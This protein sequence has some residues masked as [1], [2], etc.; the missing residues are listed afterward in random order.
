MQL[1]VLSPCSCSQFPPY[2]ATH[3]DLP[4]PELARYEAQ[5]VAITRILAVFE[6][7]DY[8]DEDEAKKAEIVKL[9]S[10]VRLSCYISQG[11]FVFSFPSGER[12][13]F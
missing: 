5:Q 7:P 9:M 8:S 3:T 11:R 10:E 2:L 4:A 1:T 6:A 12:S 13:L